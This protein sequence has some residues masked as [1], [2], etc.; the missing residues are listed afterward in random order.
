MRLRAEHRILGI[1]STQETRLE[2]DGVEN[3]SEPQGWLADGSPG[4]SD[5]AQDADQSAGVK[6]ALSTTPEESDS[7]EP[8]AEPAPEEDSASVWGNGSFGG[9]GSSSPATVPANSVPVN[10][11]SPPGS[12]SAAAADADVAGGFAGAPASSASPSSASPSG[13]FGTADAFRTSESYD[14]ASDAWGA[15]SESWG[16]ADYIA[17]ASPAP[18]ET[19]RPAPPAPA[20]V[21]PFPAPAS[22]RPA[23]PRPAQPR[24]AGSKPRQGAPRKAPAAGSAAST[25][26]AQLTVARIE[27][28]SVMKFSFMISLVGWVILFVAVAVMYF[29]LSRLGVFSS[30]ENTVG[31]VTAGKGHQGADATSWFSASRVL[32][33]TMLVG[34]VNVILI[35]ALATV[36]SVLY[37]LVTLLAGGI[38]VTLKETD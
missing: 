20:P 7:L 28:W 29:V 22:V 23:P 31:L 27:P 15:S 12:A 1:T 17:S 25:R 8:A 32:G 5:P 37:N 16:P 11:P 19:A 33:Y 38:E 24:P 4:D 26:R 2:E 18:A 36:G 34:A 10:W 14:G 21:P 13:S 6:T 30:I 9:N 35:T 3:R